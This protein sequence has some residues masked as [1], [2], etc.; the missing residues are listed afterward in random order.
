LTVCGAVGELTAKSPTDGVPVPVSVAVC[1]DPAALSA[2]DSVALR[3]VAEAGVNV[4]EME[5]LAPAARDV[6]QVL[7]WAKSLGSEPVIV[8]PVMASAALPVLESVAVCA[9]V[10]VPVMDVKVS[11]A[12]VSVATGAGGTT[13]VPLNEIV[14]GVLAALSAIV[15]EAV[16]A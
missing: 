8:M 9:A 15:T 2:T 13:P 7:V 5:Q 10:V 11:V 3:P 6:P 1:G 14:C 16:S 4:T 12:G